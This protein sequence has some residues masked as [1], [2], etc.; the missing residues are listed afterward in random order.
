M[1]HVGAL[2]GLLNQPGV[3][4]VRAGCLEEGVF[5]KTPAGEDG[6]KVKGGSVWGQG[7]GIACA[8]C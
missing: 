2:R 6:E 5:D 1:G 7:K 4:V 8:K 3:L